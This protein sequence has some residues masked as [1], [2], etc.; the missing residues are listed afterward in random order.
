MICIISGVDP[1]K[2]LIRHEDFRIKL[3]PP[4]L[5]T[6]TIPQL[7]V[8]QGTKTVKWLLQEPNLTHHWFWV[9]APGVGVVINQVTLCRVKPNPFRLEKLCKWLHCYPSHCTTLSIFL[10]RRFLKEMVCQ[11][12][13]FL[14]LPSISV[15]W[16]VVGI[17]SQSNEVL[18]QLG[19]Q[20]GKRNSWETLNIFKAAFPRA[21]RFFFLSS[22]LTLLHYQPP[23]CC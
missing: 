16:V 13:W 5:K 2:Q 17:V 8:C 22:V 14:G 9:A 12:G 21:V 19:L 1:Y 23:D 20:P 6:K 4:F 18:L 11:W 10:V 15:C 7:Q 3:S